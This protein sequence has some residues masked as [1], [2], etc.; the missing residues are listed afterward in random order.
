M[1]D[2]ASPEPKP[3]QFPKTDAFVLEMKREFPSFSIERKSNSKLQRAIG[4]FL[5]VV[6]FGG[7]RTYV[8]HYHTVLF[9]KLWVPDA[10]DRMRDVDRYILLRHERIHLRQRARMGDLLMGIYY[11]FVFFPL[12]LAYGRARIEWEAYEE[13]LRATTEELGIEEAKRLR[14]WLVERFVGP[15]YGWMW[16]FRAQVERW[17]DEA[18]AS[19][20]VESAKE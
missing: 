8:S 16:P 4:H 20:E 15:D 3:T 12:G 9:G 1:F 14:S 13:T 11:L 5:R 17:F 10:W 19:L 2:R 7:M 18:I 6:T